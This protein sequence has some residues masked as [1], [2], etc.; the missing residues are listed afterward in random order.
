MNLEGQKQKLFYE[1]ASYILRLKKFLEQN[2]KFSARCLNRIKM[3]SQEIVTSE[4]AN[5]KE[6]EEAQQQQAQ[7]LGIMKHIEKT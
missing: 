6:A 1:F 3:I 5:Q 4:E 7:N 2:Q